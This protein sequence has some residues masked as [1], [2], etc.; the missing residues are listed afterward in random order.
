MTDW[1]SVTA[2][3]MKRF[4]PSALQSP[5][6]G[7]GVR[8]EITS[9]FWDEA[10]QGILKVASLVASGTAMISSSFLRIMHELVA[11]R[12]DVDRKRAAGQEES[13]NVGLCRPRWLAM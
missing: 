2:R 10:T 12:A 9:Q 6:E 8:M 11:Q 4:S 13:I 3:E 5:R 1:H 7:P